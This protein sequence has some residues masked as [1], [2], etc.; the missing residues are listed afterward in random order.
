M[1]DSSESER[2]RIREQKKR[3]LLEK[4]GVVPESTETD[5]QTE[6]DSQTEFDSPVEIQSGEQLD[7]LVS[8]QSPVLVDCY[9]DWCGP[10][11]MM[12]P[13]IQTVAADSPAVV[14][15]VDVDAHQSL[16][17]RLGVQGIPTLVLFADGQAVERLVG[18][19]NKAALDGLIQQ[20]A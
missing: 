19:Q 13:T 15:K 3:E 4:H 11:Q 14:A 18:A 20:Y 17:G 2:E 8:E 1:S 10:C 9:A 6:V 7:R 16:A 12:E 5:S